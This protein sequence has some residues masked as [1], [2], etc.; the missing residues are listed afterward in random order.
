M[1]ATFRAGEITAQ[2]ARSR[3]G[4]ARARFYKV[5]G[6]YLTACAHHQQATW[7]PS[8][9]GGDHAPSWPPAVQALLHKRL[10]S[11]PPASYS[12]AASEVLRLCHFKI[13]RAQVRRWAIENNLAHPRPNPRATAP[14]KRWQ[15][16]R[17]AELWQLDATPHPWFPNSPRLFPMLNMLDD[18]SRVF[19]GSKIYERELLLAYLDF[20]PAAFLE[21]GLPLEIYVDFHSLFFTDDPQALTRLGQALHFYGVSFRYAHTPQAKGKVERSHFFWQERLPAYFASEQITDLDQANLHIQDLRRH[22]NQHEVHRELQM[23]PQ[24]AW[25]L[26]QQQKRSVLRPVPRC[27]WW[28]F[29]WS[30]RT[31]IKVGPDGR[32]LVGSQTWRVEAAPATK[33]ILCHHPSGHHSVLANSPAPKTKPVILFSNL[34]K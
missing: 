3:L 4:L 9:S 19:T 6:N 30:V 24:Q 32:V 11:K 21:Y 27:P 14:V 12:F 31:P 20:L 28:P 15:R 8:V 25:N 23:K 33:L 16:Q 13:D 26:A 5:Y 34:P 22:H 18:C 29:V 7:T 10:N 17:I 2:T 1:L